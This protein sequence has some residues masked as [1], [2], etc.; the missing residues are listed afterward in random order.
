MTAAG[1]AYDFRELSCFR[2]KVADG[3]RHPERSEGS[4]HSVDKFCRCTAKI[5]PLKVKLGVA[6]SRRRRRLFAGH[7]LSSP[8]ALFESAQVNAVTFFYAEALI[9]AG[10]EGSGKGNNRTCSTHYLL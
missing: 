10:A 6:K 4:P 5:P 7:S 8:L 1:R 9:A 3:F 2:I